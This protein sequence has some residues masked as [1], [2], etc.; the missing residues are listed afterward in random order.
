MKKPAIRTKA[1]TINIVLVESATAQPTWSEA[2][3]PN[4]VGRTI[5]IVDRKEALA[6]RAGLIVEL[7]QNGAQSVA[8][9]PV[10]LAPSRGARLR[11]MAIGALVTA[12]GLAGL[13]V[14]GIVPGFSYDY[15]REAPAIRALSGN[16]PD[17]V[18]T[19]PPSAPKTPASDVT[20]ADASG[21]LPT[22]PS[23]SPAAWDAVKPISKGEVE[24]ASGAPDHL[25]L[26]VKPVVSAPNTAEPEAV[27]EIPSNEL[28][29]KNLQVDGKVLDQ[30]NRAVA[31]LRET[32]AISPETL[33]SLPPQIR[34][35]MEEMIASRSADDLREGA[36]I[37]GRI[38]HLPEEVI[39]QY[40]DPAGIASIPEANT[41]LSTGG[42]IV[43]SKPGGG[44]IKKTEELR[45]FGL[46]PF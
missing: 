19:A 26:G 37:A 39:A 41:W 32:G 31:Q 2:E 4:G 30:F 28:D 12:F 1:E 23:L 34:E 42:M 10:F 29:L 17:L 43:L 18:K 16:G 13:G 14:S 11:D 15:A 7:S 36:E 27:A 38:V 3:L 44:N 8:P 45:K 21:P 25:T 22:L 35:R 24:P 9:D 40:R 46:V 20:A 6:E 5:T 33:A